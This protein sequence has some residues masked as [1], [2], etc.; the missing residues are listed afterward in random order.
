VR[1]EACPPD[2]AAKNR[3]LAAK[4][5]KLQLLRAIPAAEEHEQLEH[6]ADDDV[7]L[8]QAKATSSRTGDANAPAVSA[9]L[10]AHPIE[11]LYPTRVVESSV[12]QPQP[13]DAPAEV[14]AELDRVVPSLDERLRESE[15]AAPRASA[16]A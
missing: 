14:E 3:Q 5:E 9:A 16:A 4:D 12:E 7:G 1:L 2:L 8:T 13:N 6:A 11:H 15:S 10:A